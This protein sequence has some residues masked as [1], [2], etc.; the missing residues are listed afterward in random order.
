MLDYHLW[1]SLPKILHKSHVM[2]P[3]EF[4]EDFFDKSDL[5]FR[6]ISDK[7]IE[8]MISVC[9][10]SPECYRPE[11]NDEYFGYALTHQVLYIHI[12]NKVSIIIYT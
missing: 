11:L 6:N 8:Q 9:E 2:L 12:L 3:R 10:I 7:C 4:N 5:Y 1:T